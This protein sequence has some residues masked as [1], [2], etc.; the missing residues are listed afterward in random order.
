MPPKST[1]STNAD[2]RYGCSRCDNNNL[3]GLG[4]LDRLRKGTTLSKQQ[5]SLQKHVET[6]HPEVTDW[7]S[8]K[9]D[10]GKVPRPGTRKRK[11]T[12]IS[13]NDDQD[14]DDDEDADDYDAPNHDHSNGQDEDQEAQQDEDETPSDSDN[15]RARKMVRRSSS[16]EPLRYRGWTRATNVSAST[17]P[18]NLPVVPTAVVPIVPLLPGL[19]SAGPALPAQI[20]VPTAP[21]ADLR[22]QNIQLATSIQDYTRVNDTLVRQV[23]GLLRALT[24]V[25]DEELHAY[26]LSTLAVQNALMHWTRA[27]GQLVEQILGRVTAE[28]HTRRQ[29]PPSAPIPGPAQSA[30]ASRLQPVA[31]QSAPDAASSQVIDSS[32]SSLSDAPSD[33]E[34]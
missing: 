2:S 28:L 12:Q 30:A 1:N 9:V 26:P 20:P 6:Y 15:T 4:Y 22:E 33:M 21:V 11:A 17:T 16:T 23:Q 32:D 24:N 7:M 5:Y 29:P 34:M 31:L 8:L 19:T 10:L 18:R 27:D 14:E 25:V 13:R 3:P